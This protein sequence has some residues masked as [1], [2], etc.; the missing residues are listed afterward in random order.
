MFCELIAGHGLFPRQR[1]C[2]LV[3]T[4]SLNKRGRWGLLKNLE[5]VKREREVSPRDKVPQYH[6]TPEGTYVCWGER[7]LPRPRDYRPAFLHKISTGTTHDTRHTRHTRHTARVCG[8]IN[9][10]ST[11]GSPTEPSMVVLSRDEVME[12]LPE[13]DWTYLADA[14]GAVAERWLCF[15]TRNRHSA[16]SHSEDAAW[17]YIAALSEEDKRTYG[18]CPASFGRDS[19]STLC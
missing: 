8:Y 1:R 2:T 11:L 16:E 19:S 4:V 10:T 6:D 13:S 17:A 5:S 9:K 14:R 7:P 3:I 15:F 18:T 12:V